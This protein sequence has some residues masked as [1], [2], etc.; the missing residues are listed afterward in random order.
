MLINNTVEISGLMNDGKALL[1]LTEKIDS[2]LI[3]C[4]ECN[5]KHISYSHFIKHDEESFTLRC[6]DCNHIWDYEE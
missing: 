5:S 4:P 6:E 2:G 1:A 3:V